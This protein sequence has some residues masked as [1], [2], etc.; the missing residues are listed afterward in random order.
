MLRRF[1]RGKN[2]HLYTWK[3]QVAW[4]LGGSAC[5]DRNG[6][7]CTDKIVRQHP[8]LC[9]GSARQSDRLRKRSKHRNEAYFC[10]TA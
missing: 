10:E 7:F 4:F 3:N 9:K 1:F 2:P 6:T 5:K 8:A